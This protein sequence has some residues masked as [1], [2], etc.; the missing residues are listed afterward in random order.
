[1]AR[2]KPPMRARRR[3]RGRT[4]AFDAP[5]QAGGPDGR[6]LFIEVP[7][8]EQEALALRGTVSV[9]AKVDGVA[10]PGEL[11]PDQR[12]LHCLAVSAEL[13]AAVGKG[14]GDVVRIEVEITSSPVRTM[15]ESLSAALEANPD[16][17]ET[18]ASWS[19]REQAELIRFVAEASDAASEA[20][21]VTTALA[22]LVRN[23][24]LI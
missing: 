14:V 8:P 16:A 12:G 13:L 15:P 7:A 20:R 2:G 23:Q 22:K 5:V 9:V 4:G 10:H 1:M 11:V 19:P 3:E 21:R 6:F 17:A 24:P 18:F